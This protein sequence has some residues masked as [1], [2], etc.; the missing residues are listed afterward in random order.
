MF[1]LSFGVIEQVYSQNVL[2]LS[3]DPQALSIPKTA[4]V[5]VH[6]EGADEKQMIIMI[7]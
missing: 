7:N 5:D 3:V 4:L 2:T 6:R 1:L